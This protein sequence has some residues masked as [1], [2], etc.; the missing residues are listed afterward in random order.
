MVR[1]HTA[2][3]S[4]WH[5][6]GVPEPP[7]APTGKGRS[8]DD[9]G[10]T[11]RLPT[12]ITKGLQTCF[13]TLG[14]SHLAID[15]LEWRAIRVN[16]TIRPWSVGKSVDLPQNVH[17]QCAVGAFIWPLAQV[18]VDA[19]HLEQVELDV[20]NVRAIVRQRRYLVD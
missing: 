13:E 9:I 4:D 3:P 7:T 12:T 20:S 10:E 11:Q 14:E 17:H 2:A 8:P 6:R 1:P 18:R 5:R 16:E 19:E 15:Q